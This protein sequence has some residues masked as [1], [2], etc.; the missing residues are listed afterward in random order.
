MTVPTCG[1]TTI[2]L[3]TLVIVLT[4]S[5]SSFAE[6]AITLS[7]RDLYA[8]FEAR[9]VVLRKDGTELALD[10]RVFQFGRERKG[11]VATDPIDLGPADGRVGLPATVRGVHLELKATVPEGAAIVVEARSGAN[12][13][14]TSGWSRWMRLPGT[15]DT[16]DRLAGRYLQV[17]MTLQASSGDRLP[18][19]FGLVLRPNVERGKPWVGKLTVVEDRIQRIIRSPI[20]FHYERPDQKQIARFRQMAKLDEAVAGADDDLGKLVKLMDWVGSCHN[21]RGT[22]RE[23][24]GRI[25]TW[26]IGRVFEVD[27]EGKPCIYGHCMSYA[28]VMVTAAI[29]L[30]YVGARH[31]AVCGFREASHEVC[32]IWVPSLGKWVYFDPSLTHYYFDKRTRVPLSLIEMHNVIA[33]RFLKAGEDMH[34]WRQRRSQATHDR[35]RSVGGQKHIGCRTG[36]WHYGRPAGKDYDWGWYHGYLAAGFVQMTPRNDFHSHPEAIPRQLEHYPG[37]AGYPNWVDDKTP[38]TRGAHNWYTR[39]RD[40]YWTLDQ[41]AARLVQAGEGTLMVELGHSMPF[42]AAYRLE[43]DGRR[44]GNP[45]NPFVWEL[46]PGLNTLR[47]APADEFGKLGIASSV[48]VRYTR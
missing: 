14:D 40:F 35:V 28:E 4:A 11:V 17:R 29:A 10:A 46:K 7:A 37:Y 19:L 41:A 30:G 36:P 32:E 22:R 23:R 42:F 38:P 16:L 48:T 26:N 34:W 3:A 45:E 24:D 12:A 21:I 20:V 39:P 27:K 44:V 9:K 6:G 47:V 33:E 2:G 8:G 15:T 31:M 43:V 1:A 18:A 5:C 25:Y 13:L